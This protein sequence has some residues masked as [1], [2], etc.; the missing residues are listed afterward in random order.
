LTAAPALAQPTWGQNPYAVPENPAGVP[1]LSA[2]SITTT[3]LTAG[4]V[5]YAGYCDGLPITNAAWTPTTDCGPFSAGI[6]AP[7]STDSITWGGNPEANPPPAASILL[8]HG[9]FSNDQ[10]FGEQ[11]FNCLA[12]DDSPTATVT[13]EGNEPIDPTEPAWGGNAVPPASQGGSQAPCNLIISTANGTGTTSANAVEDPVSLAPT[14]LVPE[15]RLAIELPIG[16]AVLFL[17]AGAY[18]VRRR[19]RHSAAA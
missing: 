16:A 10:V 7:A 4:T 8:W 1:D 12:P 14:N 6:P 18:A 19:R 17:G 5:Y 15:S 3:G 9:S 11:P 13:A 2:V